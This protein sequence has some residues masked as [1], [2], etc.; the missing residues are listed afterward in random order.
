[1]VRRLIDMLCGAYRSVWR[2]VRPILGWCCITL[3]FVWMVLPIPFG[4]PLVLLGV[5]LLGHRD[6]R[7]RWVWM[8]SRL[9]LRRMARCSNPLIR[10]VGRRGLQM[11]RYVCGRG[12]KPGPRDSS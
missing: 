3:G 8:H 12:Y 7:L 11:H 4:F 2:A 10:I 1:M 6:P 5:A 9:L